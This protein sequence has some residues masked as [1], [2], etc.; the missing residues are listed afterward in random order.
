MAASVYILTE[1][2]RNRAKLKELIYAATEVA[3]LLSA[4]TAMD[5]VYR[6]AGNDKVNLLERK[7]LKRLEKAISGVQIA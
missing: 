4:H 1:D 7:A 5:I 2:D 3:G 6:E